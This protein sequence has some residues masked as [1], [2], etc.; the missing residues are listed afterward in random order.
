MI[1]K[2]VSSQFPESQ[3]KEY[4]MMIFFLEKYYEWANTDGN[5]LSRAN[6]FKQD[7]DIDTASD[8]F[9]KSFKKQYLSQLNIDN[10]YNLNLLLKHSKELSYAKGTARGIDLFFKLVFGV[11]ASVTIPGNYIFKTSEGNWQVPR[12]I[13]I[14]IFDVDNIKEGKEIFG[15][16][17]KATAY[18]KSLQRIENKC[19]VEIESIDGSFIVGEYVSPNSRILGSVN[20]ISTEMTLAPGT[21]YEFYSATGREGLAYSINSSALAVI[22]SGYGFKD[23]ET[24]TITNGITTGSGTIVNKTA[25][26]FKEG[27]YISNYSS[28]SSYHCLQ[29]GEYYQEFSYEISSPISKDKYEKTFLPMMHPAGF[30]MFGSINHD[31][32]F[33]LQLNSNIIS[34]IQ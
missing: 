18:I 24:I 29:D 21:K 15:R 20:A 8:D 33:Q 23:L 25:V 32:E 19:L 9:L 13:E 17:S 3:R 6:T 28:T 12:Y 7:I 34:E 10:V 14:D 1:D 30:K 16:T 11:P 2:F 26:G 27:D 22:E 5:F 31:T 4:E